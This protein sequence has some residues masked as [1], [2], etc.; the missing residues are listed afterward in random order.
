MRF[1][2]SLSQ[3]FKSLYLRPSTLAHTRILRIGRPVSLLRCGIETAD[4]DQRPF[5]H[6]IKHVTRSRYTYPEPAA[7]SASVALR[8][9]QHSQKSPMPRSSG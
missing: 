9:S 3:S 2:T 4:S 8:T 7:T 5:L 1:L 6:K